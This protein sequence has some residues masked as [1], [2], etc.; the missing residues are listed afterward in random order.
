MASQ[1]I[2]SWNQIVAWLRGNENSASVAS[3]SLGRIV[4]EVLLRVII[5]PIVDSNSAKTCMRL[6]SSEED[7]AR[8]LAEEH[9]ILF[10]YVDWSVY[11]VQG[12]QLVE[13][14]ESTFNQ[15]LNASCWIADVSDVDASPSLLGEW[16]KKQDR[17]GLGMFIPVLSGNGSVAWLARGVVIDFIQSATHYKLHHLRNRTREA[18][19]NAA[20]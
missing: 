3:D 6:I 2:P 17:A 12:R 7:F 19:H 15:D 20:T 5:P 9:S 8:V 16:L 14:L 1:S 11:A 18:F 10:F 13:E 4:N